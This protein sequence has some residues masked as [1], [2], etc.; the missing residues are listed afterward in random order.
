MEIS[1]PKLERPLMS[2]NARNGGFGN[3]AKFPEIIKLMQIIA[4]TRLI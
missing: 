1:F 4:V 2:R 3:L